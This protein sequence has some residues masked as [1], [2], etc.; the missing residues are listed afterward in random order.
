MENFQSYRDNLAKKVK[1][2]RNS[3]KKNP[4]NAKAKAEG[5]LEAKQGTKQYKTAE[6]LQREEFKNR[7][8]QKALDSLINNNTEIEIDSYRK[9]SEEKPKVSIGGLFMGARFETANSWNKEMNRSVK[10]NKLI[11]GNDIFKALYKQGKNK[12]FLRLL[13]ASD[14]ARRKILCRCLCNKET[15]NNCFKTTC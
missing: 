8:L 2:I 7:E 4:A 9:D 15:W 3:N 5:Y 11:I 14:S 12:S 10:K 13:H 1:E 6:K